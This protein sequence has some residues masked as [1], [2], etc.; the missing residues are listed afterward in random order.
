MRKITFSFFAFLMLSLSANAAVYYVNKDATGTGS[1]T[2]WTNAYTTIEA[3]FSNAVVGDQVWVASGVYKP[4][5]TSYTMPNGVKLYGGFAGTETALSQR[6]LAVNTTTLNG[7]IGTV[8]T[9]TDNCDIIISVTNSSALTFIDGFRFINAY[10][11]SGNL[12]GAIRVTGGS[13]T[14]QNCEFIANFGG[15]GASISFASPSGMLNVLDC[16]INNNNGVTGPGIYAQEGT[17]TVKDTKIQ[18]NIASNYGGA[19]YSLWAKVILDRCDVSGNSADDLA[20]AFYAGET[21]TYEIYN[22]LIVG[23]FSD[24][25]AVLYMAP[26][27]N[28]KKHKIVNCTISGN[29]NISTDVNGSNLITLSYSGGCWF[30]NNIMWNNT[31]PVML[32]NGSVRKSIINGRIVV[33]DA[34]GVSTLNPGLVNIGNPATAPFSTDGFDYHLQAG[35][36]AVNYG[37]NSYVNSLYNTDL[38]KYGRIFDVAVDAGCY[39]TQVL[40]TDGFN[41]SKVAYYFNSATKELTFIKNA[42]L[43]INE[44][45]FVY[46]L[47]GRQV[48]TLKITGNAV[49]LQNLSTGYYVVKAGEQEGFKILVN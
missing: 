46:D 40:G 25:N 22:S 31:A 24:D 8:G 27:S 4:S 48:K 11:N 34:T 37:Q 19:V 16:K 1:G 43:L 6:D 5:G 47:S 14:I 20:G 36:R 49:S 7:D 12:G 26:I 39:E 42:E 9:A 44:Q 28:E 21:A 23:N 38:D 13:A 2:S 41:D 45:L 35:A 33:D 3:A 15:K 10:N 30:Y 32:L 17:V 29:R 18:S